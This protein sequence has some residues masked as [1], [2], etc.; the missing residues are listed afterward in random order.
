MDNHFGSKRVWAD[1]YVAWNIGIF[2]KELG[3]DEE[4]IVK[5]LLDLAEG[6]ADMSRRDTVDVIREEIWGDNDVWSDEECF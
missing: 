3:V 4:T 5:A 2:A 1:E 6:V